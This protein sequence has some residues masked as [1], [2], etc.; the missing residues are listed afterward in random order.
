VFD[1]ETAALSVQRSGHIKDIRLCPDLET[2]LLDP[3]KATVT[4]QAEPGVLNKIFFGAKKKHSGLVY[5]DYIPLNESNNAH[6]FKFV[7]QFSE[8][9]RGFYYLYMHNCFNFRGLGFSHKVAVD[10]TVKIKFTTLIN[11]YFR[12]TLLK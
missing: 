12:L 4:P 5:Q 7:I 6:S 10:L 8:S 1:F 3:T 11:Y 9:Q 2:C